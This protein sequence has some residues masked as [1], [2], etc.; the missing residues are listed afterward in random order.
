MANKRNLKKYVRYTCGALASEIRIAHALFPVIDR[1]KV[2]DIVVEIAGLQTTTLAKANI[3][4]AG[5][6]DKHEDGGKARNRAARAVYY[7]EA[8]NKLLDEFDARV[9]YIVKDMNAALP[10]GVRM[11]L[12]QAVNS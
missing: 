8:Y 2:Y 4:F 9:V 12:K 10:E 5:V 6:A 3:A 1:K 7:R 11:A